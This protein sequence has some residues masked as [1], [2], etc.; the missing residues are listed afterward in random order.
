MIPA[1]QD[2]PWQEHLAAE[3]GAL[4]APT[5]AF[6]QHFLQTRAGEPGIASRV[7]ADLRSFLSS[8]IDPAHMLGLWAQDTT[9]LALLL[10][11]GG[12]SRYGFQVACR[13]PGDFTMIV[14]EGQHRQ[15]WGNRLMFTALLAEMKA[16]PDRNQERRVLARFKHRHFLRLILGDLSGVL[17]FPALV[18]ELSD[19]VDVLAQAAYAMAESA[20]LA[21][22]PAIAALP[23]EQ[24]LF[25]VLAMG[26]HGARELN[27]SSDIDLIFLY[28]S[29]AGG[30]DDT[31]SDLHDYHQRLGQELIRIL[32]NPSDDGQLFRVDMRLR[33]E[34]DRGELVLSVRETIDYYYSVGRPWERQ[35]MIKARAIAGDL[36]LGQHLVDELRPWVYPQEPEWETLDESRSMRRRIE[37][38][39]QEA[40]VKTGAGGI[41]D[42]EFL[43]QY[44]QLVYGGRDPE[45][46][47]R[48]TLP[49]LRLLADRG[50]IPGHDAR[51]LEEYYIWLRVVE[52]RLQMWEDRQE[53]ELPAAPAQ[54]TALAWR[55]DVTGPDALERFDRRHTQ[56]RARVREIVAR[57]FLATTQ[58]ED[59]MLALV[60]QGEADERLAGKY[61]TKAGLKDHVKACANL[62]KLA[63]EPFF[64]LSRG[65][66]ERSLSKIL[67]LL[68]HLVSQSPSPD[69]ALANFTRIV[70]AVGGRA[71]FYDLLGQQAEILTLFVDLAAWSE[72]LVTLLHDFQGLPDELIDTLNQRPRGSAV[73]AS[74]ARSLIAGLT[75]PAEPL[76]FMVARETAA[77]ALRDLEGL[78]QAEVGRQLSSVAQAVFGALL[79]KVIAERAH[80]WG[81]PLEGHRP[82][83]FAVLGLGKLGSREQ[84]YASDMD[85]LFVSDPGGK[86]PRADHDGDEFWTRVSQ[87]LMRVMQEGRLYEIDPRLRPWGDGGPLVANTEALT[88]YWRERRELWERMAMLRIAHLAGDP[89][90]GGEALTLIRNAAFTQPLD[91]SAATEV[92]DMRR[93]LEESVAGRDHVKRGWGG[94]VDH[95]FTAQYLS[96][97]LDPAAMPIGCDIEG[98]FVRLAELGRMPPEAVPELTASLRTLRFAE[99]RMRLAAGKAISSLPTDREARMHLAK[100]CNYPDLAA[101]DLALHLARETGRRWFDRLVK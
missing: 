99:A 80:E 53:H 24:R 51:R 4:A 81:V 31:S 100:R 86:C 98:M 13:H 44:F 37:E 58:E 33:P 29:T 47:N 11:L 40:N 36:A 25:S 83:R 54:R 65:R 76:A 91:G 93:R 35:A 78:S 57:H 15:V 60:V 94:Y 26:K 56:V 59:A 32:E 95:E 30:L 79:P 19:V 48:A 5:L 20:A 22:F 66:T 6:V 61:L 96:L 67:P 14:R 12:I 73:L 55:C 21:R 90:L 39:A 63:A 69:Q 72:F 70:Q 62:R 34:G 42:I 71:T 97:G 28:R 43:V 87:T 52:H 88:I 82:T 68:L 8:C 50:T 1:M 85:V 27:Y 7:A 10:R 46:R 84:T 38:R 75:S 16:T 45:L 49:T 9:S 41:R 17:G 3:H 92:R 77:V 18:H 101:F 89:Q 2:V 74:E 64:V 23:L